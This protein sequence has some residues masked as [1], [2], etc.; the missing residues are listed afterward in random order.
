MRG[1][2]QA[3]DR[4]LLAQ[5]AVRERT[6]HGIE[7]VELHLR[8]VQV[9]QEVLRKGPQLLRRLH[10]PV[11]H[12]VRSDLED[13]RGAANAQTLSEAADHVHDEVNRDAL[14][15]EQGALGL[16]KVSIAVGAVQL[17]PRPTAGM[18]IG[19]EVAQAEPAAIATVGSRTELLGGVDLT[20]ASSRRDHQRWRGAGRL[21][22]RRDALFTGVAGGLTGR[23][24]K[25]LGV[26]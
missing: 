21:T 10:Q 19:P 9:V 3:L 17:T 5:R 4:P 15:V 2:R 25:G 20:P 24:D 11:Q 18:A 8:E 26:A 12:R 13:P 16:Q 23:A 6:E 22:A 1:A 7:F 14:A